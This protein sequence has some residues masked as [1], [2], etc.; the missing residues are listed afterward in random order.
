M[1][2]AAGNQ[3]KE[4]ITAAS[5]RY[6]G[7]MFAPERELRSFTLTNEPITCLSNQLPA[8]HQPPLCSPVEPQFLHI[9]A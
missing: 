1:T 4:I 5:A 9:F 7:C 3:S 2:T 8:P 6:R